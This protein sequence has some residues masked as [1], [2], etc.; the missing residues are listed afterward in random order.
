MFPTTVPTLHGGLLSLRELGEQDIPAWF[1]RATDVEA[2]DLAGD[3][4]PDSIDR[5]GP[6]LQRQ[7]DLLHRQAGIR[8]AIV[9]RGSLLSVGTV[10]LTLSAGQPTVAEL[11]LVLARSHWGQGLGTAGARMAMRHGFFEL[12]L[13]EIR[14][15]VLQRN[16]ASI[17]LLE[18]AG[19]KMIRALPP[20]DAE[21]EAMILYALSR[22][23]H[24]AG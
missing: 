20:S 8:W 14:A 15:E 5:G 19:L 17:R 23:A 1:A 11:G 24:G 7:R 13:T 12:G 3:P 10:G 16:P 18:K 2:A 22:P 9:P 4:V 6:W 21:P